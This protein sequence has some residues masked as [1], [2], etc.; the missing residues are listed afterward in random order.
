MLL[1]L[2]LPSHTEIQILSY[3]IVR[4]IFVQ[5]MWRI[6]ESAYC[7]HSSEILKGQGKTAYLIWKKEM[8]S[9]TQAVH[10]KK[11]LK[12]VSKPASHPLAN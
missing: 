10:L 7:S 5:N 11:R 4:F 1:L 9:N 12:G 3:K 2:I 8:M 6:K